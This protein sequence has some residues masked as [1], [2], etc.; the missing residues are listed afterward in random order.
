M[1]KD[2]SWI[3]TIDGTYA[4]NPAVSFFAEYA[5][6]NYHTRMISRNRSPLSGTQPDILN[7][8]GCDSANNDWESVTR[9]IFDTYTIG[10]DFFFKKRIWFS[11]YYSLSAGTGNVL[12]RA[13]GTATITNAGCSGAPPLPANC[14]DA[15]TLTNAVENYPETVVRS[16]DLAAVVKIKITKNLMPKFEYRFQQWDN[17]DYQTTPMTQ[18]MGCIGTTTTVVN[19]PCPNTP[20]NNLF[21]KI[22]SPFYPGFVVG[23]TA[24]ARYLFLGADQ[25]SFRA[26]IFTATL[27]WH[28]GGG[29]KDEK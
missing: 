13:L 15:F 14:T 25:P 9:D 28:F 11:P 7:C 1:L 8:S 10:F 29:A 18:Y 22:P 6:E 16:H 26:H 3:Y 4:F 19:P 2:D 20:A 12:T 27:E 17:K 5:R 24:A 21:V 23:D